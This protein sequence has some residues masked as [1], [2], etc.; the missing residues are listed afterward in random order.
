MWGL[1]MNEIIGKLIGGFG[2]LECGG[3]IGECFCSD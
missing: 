1:K 2:W 3:N